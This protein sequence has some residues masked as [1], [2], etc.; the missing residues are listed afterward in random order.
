[1]FKPLGLNNPNIICALLIGLVAKEL[2]LSSFAISNGITDV[3]LLGLSLVCSTSAVSFNSATGIS[4]LVFTLLYFPC[5]SNFG[6]MIKQ[7]GLKHT[8]IGSVLQVGLAYLASY[9]IYT[10][11]TRGVVYLLITLLVFIL[12]LIASKK[13]YT[14]IKTN[15]SC[16]NCL[17]CDRCNK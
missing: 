1:M 2:I 3:K 4:F 8:L 13:I 12:V 15:K 10:L 6:V 17:N 11:I 9:I 5:I 16:C 7:I 14:K